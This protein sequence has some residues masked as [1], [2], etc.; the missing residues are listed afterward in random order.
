MK[1]CRA[2]VRMKKRRWW[3]ET[4]TSAAGSSLLSHLQLIHTNCFSQS[5]SKLSCTVEQLTYDSV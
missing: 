1:R 2:W 5:L 3:R 4:V